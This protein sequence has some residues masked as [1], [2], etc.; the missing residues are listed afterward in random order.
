M[1]FKWQILPFRWFGVLVH[2]DSRSRIRIAIWHDLDWDQHF[3]NSWKQA[4]YWKHVVRGKDYGRVQ[5]M[6]LV[7]EWRWGQKANR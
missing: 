1:P 5:V 7:V 4:S 2:G 3:T 6:D